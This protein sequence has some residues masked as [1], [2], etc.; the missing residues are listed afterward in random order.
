MRILALDGSLARAS[1]AL[2]IDG[3]V[4]AA[5]AVPGDRVQPTAL[6][7]MA[8][9]LLAEA[10]RRLDAV[11]VVVGPGSFTGVRTAIA[12]AEG[13]ALGLG[14]PAIGVTTG[15]ALAAALPEALRAGREVWAAVDTKRGRMALERLL[16]GVAAAP[17]AVFA[18][19]D[20]PSPGGPVTVV[21]DAAPVMAARLL[22]RGFDTVLSDSRL[23]DAAAAASVAALR[24]ERKIPMRGAAPLYAEPPAV[25][26]PG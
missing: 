14:V 3:S 24:I 13:V 16:D 12:L 1:A 25:R 11:A 6:P 26:L 18:E 5:R 20:L 22:A 10:G 15:E 2:W 7:A 4:A 23:P 9:T 21:G 17:P 19:R 8:E